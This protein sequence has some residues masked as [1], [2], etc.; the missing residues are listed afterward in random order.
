MYSSI[1]GSSG[2]D[3]SMVGSLSPE[4]VHLSSR[5]IDAA[6]PAS[7]DR[8][9]IAIRPALPCIVAIRIGILK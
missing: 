8:G 4:S 6:V 9:T 5:S 2:S 7:Q 3:R 1:T